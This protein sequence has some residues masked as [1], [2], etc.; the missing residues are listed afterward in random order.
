MN[1]NS[2][3]LAKLFKTNIT[4]VNKYCKTKIKKQLKFNYLNEKENNDLI[5][6]VLSKIFEDKQII[7]S[8][9]RKN[10]W[11]S[12]LNETLNIYKKDK[13]CKLVI[14]KFYTARKIGILDWVGNL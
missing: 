8:R 7:A 2:S 12:R 4:E 13:K 10:K 5:I 9:G 3:I 11:F 14:S 1:I 6:K